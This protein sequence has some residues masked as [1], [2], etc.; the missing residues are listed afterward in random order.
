LSAR[1]ELAF[2][3]AEHDDRKKLWAKRD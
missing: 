1:V 2:H 3:D